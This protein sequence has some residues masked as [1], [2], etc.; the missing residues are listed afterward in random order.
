MIIYIAQ[1]PLKA[2]LLYPQDYVSQ[3]NTRG[4]ASGICQR[5][6][7]SVSNVF[8]G[9]MCQIFYICTDFQVSERFHG[10]PEFSGNYLI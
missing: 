4:S 6:Q 7:H 9:Y 3:E 8:A 10:G 1:S 5:K 2:R